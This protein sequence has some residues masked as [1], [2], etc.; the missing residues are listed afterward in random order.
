MKTFKKTLL[1]EHMLTLSKFHDSIYEY[2][3]RLTY[4]FPYRSK[5]IYWF[6]NMLTGNKNIIKKTFINKKTE[7]LKLLFIGNNIFCW[8]KEINKD[9]KRVEK[10]TVEYNIE[11]IVVKTTIAGKKHKKHFQY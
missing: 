11:D 9:Y 5:I 1:S 7:S 4:L 10:V 3:V 6:E 8:M 2:Y